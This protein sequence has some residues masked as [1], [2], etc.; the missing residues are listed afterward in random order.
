MGDSIFASLFT[1][2][3]TFNWTSFFAN[4]QEVIDIILASL[5][6]YFNIQD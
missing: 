6:N 5:K 2:L 1:T 4:Y 3:L